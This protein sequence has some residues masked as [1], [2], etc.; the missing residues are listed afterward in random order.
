[1][2]ESSQFGPSASGPSE[3]QSLTEEVP[4]AL[5]GE[6]LDRVVAMMT[7]ASRAVVAEQVAAGEVTVN[8]R[9][10]TQRSQRVV[11]GDVV[12]APPAPEV[13]DA[14]VEPDATVAF[15][16]VFADDQVVVIDKPPGLVVHPGAGNPTE[17]LVHGLVARFP[18]LVDVGQSGRPGIV[19][20]LDAE[21]SGLM[22]VARTPQ[23]Y[24]DLVQQLAERTVTRC[25]DALVWGEFET[26]SGRIDAPIGRSRRHPTR[27][28]VTAD[29][30]EAMTDYEVL[31]TFHDPV[32]VSRLRCSLHSGRTHQIRVHL[33]SIGRPVVGDSLYRGDRK[34]LRVPRLW[35]H[36]AELSFDHPRSGER[37]WFTAPLPDD[38][39]GVLEGL[40]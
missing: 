4:P 31:T 15:E 28:A 37:L 25:Y 2:P 24:G 36:A 8:G 6:R 34:G 10:V 11:T 33:A 29:G 1:M 26:T 39:A 16:V 13:L 20:R 23:A 35:L 5:D 14:V 38:L 27:M 18:E 32:T 30:R 19:H 17:T 12:A 7:G 22:V 3:L 21:T 9:A 40:G